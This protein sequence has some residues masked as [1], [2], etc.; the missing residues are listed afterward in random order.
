MPKKEASLQRE[1]SF[2]GSGYIYRLSGGPRSEGGVMQ[3]VNNG[4][5]EG[6]V[7]DEFSQSGERV[8]FG[9]RRHLGR[10]CGRFAN[11]SG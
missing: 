5:V 11:V 9:D 8:E 2:P 1:A 4:L 10:M 6:Q 7:T 3:G